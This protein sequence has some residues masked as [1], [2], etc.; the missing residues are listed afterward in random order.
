M[1]TYIKSG[2]PSD[3]LY[4][5]TYKYHVFE[6]DATYS[7]RY[8]KCIYNILREMNVGKSAT[9]KRDDCHSTIVYLKH[10]RRTYSFDHQMLFG[11]LYTH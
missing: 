2:D 1:R 3:A 9:R 5:S 8:D 10:R 7:A 4:F 6:L 11:I